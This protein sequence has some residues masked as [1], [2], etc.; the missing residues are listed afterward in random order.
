VGA[1]PFLQ[2]HHHFER[3]GSHPGL[4]LSPA[5]TEYRFPISRWFPHFRR[6]SVFLTRDEPYTDSYKV[7]L[8]TLFRVFTCDAVYSGSTPKVIIE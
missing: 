5:V 6:R 1:L 8:L 4:R 2:F 7:H 3:G